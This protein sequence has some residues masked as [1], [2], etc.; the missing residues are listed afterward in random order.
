MALEQPKKA[1]SAYW[2][3]LS[4]NR[5]DISKKVGTSKGSV[6]AK[7]AGDAW[8]TLPAAK[9]APYEKKA[10]EQKADFEK[11]MAAFKDA[12]GVPAARKSKKD[13]EGKT[14]KVK[15]ANAP[16]KPVG[17]AYGCFLAEK[18][19]GIKKSLPKDHKITD[20]A[21]KAGE[22]WA[23]VSEADR[24]KYQDEFAAK[25]AA[26]K[27]EME[28]YKKNGGG[29]ADEDEEEEEE[30]A[31]AP[32]KSPAK[33]RAKPEEDAPKSPAKRAKAA[34]KS[35]AAKGKAKAKAK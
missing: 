27:K 26:Y 33:K 31:E 35:P 8:K 30:E 6:V 34:A 22:M 11:A 32:A 18:R 2:L 14:K 25:S 13:K 10:A 16:K 5:A 4:D 21:K 24:K 15:D 28:E 3:W 19:E 7:A 20:V 29:D 9:K 17:G 1:V 12:G 23:K